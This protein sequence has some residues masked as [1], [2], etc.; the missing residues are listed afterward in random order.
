[1][2]C[3]KAVCHLHCEYF[4]VCRVN[5]VVPKKGLTANVA[6]SIGCR[7]HVQRRARRWHVPG[8]QSAYAA[9]SWQS[10]H[11]PIAPWI[12]IANLR[13]DTRVQDLAFACGMIVFCIHVTCMHAICA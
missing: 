12:R 1:M 11:W 4:V 10:S 5:P 2:R 9:S 8:L 6:K 13:Y 3:S 7:Q